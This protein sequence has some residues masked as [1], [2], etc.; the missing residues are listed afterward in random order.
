MQS[1]SASWPGEE[2]ELRAQEVSCLLPSSSPS[3]WL[4][5]R[6]F[7]RPVRFAR[8]VLACSSNASRGSSTSASWCP[9]S[10]EDPGCA[11]AED[12]IRHMIPVGS[13]EARG[14][15]GRRALR[16]AR[17]C[18]ACGRSSH[19]PRPRS[20]WRS[21]SSRLSNVLRSY[22][23]LC[24]WNIFRRVSD[25]CAPGLVTR[26]D[27]KMTPCLK[28]NLPSAHHTHLRGLMADALVSWLPDRVASL[29][30]RR[31]TVGNRSH[32][33]LLPRRPRC[34]RPSLAPPILNI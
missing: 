9:S 12:G 4:Y 21:H 17:G 31:E 29:I 7:A 24:G 5:A 6:C 33:P 18:A 32:S 22:A 1:T 19:P 26:L 13:W 27:A 23:S 10:T 11:L 3:S 28:R 25:V 2:G 30:R 34:K 8:G 20:P 15:C 14:A 16:A